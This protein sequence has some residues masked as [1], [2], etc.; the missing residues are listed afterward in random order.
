MAKTLDLT[1]QKQEFTP[2]LL[3]GKDAK[4]L[5]D[6]LPKQVRVGLRYDKDSNTV[7]GSTPFA[8]AVLDVEAQKYG[9]RTPNLRDLSRP[10]VMRIAEGKHYI[11]SRNLVARSTTDQYWPKNNPL[12]K[13]I[14]ELAEEKEGRVKDGFMIEG[15]TFVLNPEDKNSFGLSIVA[16]PDFKVFQDERF[17]GHNG[18]NFS[19]V[20]ELGIPL[21]DK[22]G[23]RA[24]YAKDNGLSR[25][26]LDWDLDLDSGNDSLAGSGDDGRVVFLK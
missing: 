17:M 11:D 25:L 2:A 18:D 23:S 13:Q 14:Y 16:R 19:E 24:W 7:L 6:S 1:W 5:Y 3:T 8:A 20:D 26:C 9:A 10:E 4:K 21:F 12:L 15:Y 22:K